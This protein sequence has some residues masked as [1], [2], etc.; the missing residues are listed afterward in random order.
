M[1][2]RTTSTLFNLEVLLCLLYFSTKCLCKSFKER[3][4]R[5]GEQCSFPFCE[6][7]GTVFISNGKAFAKKISRNIFLYL[8]LRC[9][10]ILIFKHIND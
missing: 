4:H 9:I 6:C 5:D 10:F 3:L 1:T 7:K 2:T 8:L